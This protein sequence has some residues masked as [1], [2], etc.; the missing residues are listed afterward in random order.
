MTLGRAMNAFENGEGILE[1]REFKMNFL[2][3]TSLVM[4]L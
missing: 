3:V 1:Y 4:C 2:R